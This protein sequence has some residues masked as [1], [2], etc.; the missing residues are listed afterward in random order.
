MTV[1]ELLLTRQGLL[2]PIRGMSEGN[3]TLLRALDVELAALGYALSTRLR[4]QLATLAPDDLARTHQWVWV[5]LAA[6]LGAG[7]RH[8]PLFRN[9]PRDVPEDTYDLGSAS[10]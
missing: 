5:A 3:H 1:A 7:H 9:F 4:Q 6:K 2:S 10:F 8:E